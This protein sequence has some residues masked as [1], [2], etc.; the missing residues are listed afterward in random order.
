MCRSA[1]HNHITHTRPSAA[2]THTHI[3]ACVQ[4]ALA[5]REQSY[6]QL[7]QELHRMRRGLDGGSRADGAPRSD[8]P[9]RPP[10][11]PPGACTV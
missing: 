3:T 9:P 5:S 6:D 11:Y 2:H 8:S 10:F 1:T 7:L 4:A